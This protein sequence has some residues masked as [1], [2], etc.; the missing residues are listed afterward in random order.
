MSNSLPQ[1]EILL[2]LKS[3]LDDNKIPFWL[4]TG[5]LLGAIRD[6]DFIKWDE[7]DIDIG[8][9]IKYYWDVKKL[10][11]NS[12]FKIKHAWIKEIAIY[13]GD[14]VHPH[15]DL[16]FH[17]F[18]D[19]FSYCYM[20]K[21]SKVSGVWND[22]WRLKSPKKYLFPL[23]TI[24]FLE[25]DFKAPHDTDKF[26]EDLY[27]AD[28]RIPNPNWAYTNFNT[29][30]N[31]YRAITA[32]V[33]TF[34]RDECI[35]KLIT[36]FC[37]LYPDIK[38]IIGNQNPQ[39]I[40]CSYSNVEIIELPED[41]GLSYARN[42]LVKHVNTEFTLLLDDDFV[43]L[44]NS[45]IFRLLEVFSYDKDIGIVG[46]RLY[47]NKEI[48]SYERFLLIMD[49]ILL[50]ID[51]YKLLDKKHVNE[52]SVNG[53]MFGYA[54]IIFNFFLAKTAV[55]RRY[56]WDNNHKIHSEHIDFFLNLKINSDV[57]IAFVPDV[58]IQHEPIKSSEKYAEARKR[59][60]YDLIYEKYGIEKGYAI[61]ETAIINYK[62]N[63]KESL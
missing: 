53:I 29:I 51:W 54:D 44:K 50:L 47:Q 26:L 59:M 3:L 16:F 35:T 36:S 30:D 39:K 14:N 28:W 38:L 56:P 6:K 58:L 27:G 61:G 1:K 21:P 13:H 4:Q 60:Y 8:L 15:I 45:N 46:G 9:D 32:I 17:T 34:N 2:K 25:E 23:K 55:L 42:E 40:E 19:E 52:R 37:A 20:Y 11:D 48:K 57:R 22:E 63:K 5:T 43:F 31:D 33:P 62:E 10:L 7:K 24:K 12:D 41:C 49:K 18:D